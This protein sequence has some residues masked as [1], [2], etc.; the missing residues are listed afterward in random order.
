MCLPSLGVVDIPAQWDARDAKRGFGMESPM[1]VLLVWGLFLGEWEET[2]WVC[3]T[4]DCV[5]AKGFLPHW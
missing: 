4:N 2:Q 1:G 5:F 3:G